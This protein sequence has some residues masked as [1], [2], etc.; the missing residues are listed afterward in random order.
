MIWDTKDAS[1]VGVIKV[2]EKI[3]YKE[4]YTQAVLSDALSKAYKDAMM[5]NENAETASASA[6]K[7]LT[8]AIDAEHKASDASSKADGAVS[9]ANSANNLAN[10][11]VTD[12]KKAQ[13][14]AKRI[15][16]VSDEA[17]AK[18][19]EAI[20]GFNRFDQV[21][22]MDNTGLKIKASADENANTL[23][24]TNDGMQISAVEKV[25]AEYTATQSRV[26]NL[27]AENFLYAGAHRFE[28]TTMNTEIGTGAF[29]VG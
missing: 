12:S 3:T 23:Q 15:Q 28:K 29:Y 21:I 24:L 5:A 27:V 25:V 26:K 6:N 11:A 16:E 18:A 19:R 10:Q 1:R 7:A 17:N 8:A 4:S 20:A 13:E 14:E 22:K 9:T 2:G